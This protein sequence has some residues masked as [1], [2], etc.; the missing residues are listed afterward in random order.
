MRRT[1]ISTALLAALAA[2]CGSQ[3]GGSGV[4]SVT[5]T[6]AK[7]T[8]SATPTATADRQEQGRK[9]AQCM[10]EHGVPMEDPD[11]NGGGGLNLATEGIDRGKVNDAIEACRAHA[12]FRDREA[13]KPEDVEKLRQF[14]QCM[15]DNGVDM[16]DPSPDGTFGTGAAKS[17]NRDDPTYRKAI[18]VCNEKFPRMGAR[19]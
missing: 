15:R 10:R 2:G 9:F 4:A 5:A 11:P 18:E 16:P 7:P 6:S 1:L 19:Q 3:Q 13:L 14:A 17:F 8:A 12:P